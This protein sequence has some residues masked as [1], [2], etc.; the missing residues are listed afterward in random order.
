MVDPLSE[1]LGEQN[2]G[3]DP[4]QSQKI[5]FSD[6]EATLPGQSE[7]LRRRIDEEVYGLQLKD[8]QARST[9]QNSA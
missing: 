6:Q 2:L 9:D 4:D 1:E 8:R 5:D 3:R 7:S